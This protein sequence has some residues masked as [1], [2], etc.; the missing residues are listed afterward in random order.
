[1]VPLIGIRFLEGVLI[2]TYVLFAIVIPFFVVYA[3]KLINGWALIPGIIT[4]VVGF[5]FL[6]AE[7]AVRYITPMVLIVGGVRLASRPIIQKGV[8]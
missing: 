6:I 8:D 2:T 7:N 1:M 4:A 3:C 5:P